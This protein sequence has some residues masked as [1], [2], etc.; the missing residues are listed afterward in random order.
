MLRPAPRATASSKQQTAN[1]KQTRQLCFY[2]R[3][4]P[5]VMNAAGNEDQMNAMQAAKR[6]ARAAISASLRA[7]SQESIAQQCT[8]NKQPDFPPSQT[9]VVPLVLVLATAVIVVVVSSQSQRR[10]CMQSYSVCR[11]GGARRGSVCFCRCRRAR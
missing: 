1:G 6:E 4:C 7:V 3:S 10:W 8:C 5:L 2:A 9:A 11:N